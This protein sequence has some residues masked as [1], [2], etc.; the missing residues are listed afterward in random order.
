MF[1]WFK[2]ILISIVYGI[3]QLLFMHIAPK[4]IKV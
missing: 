3:S 1:N 4:L 2:L